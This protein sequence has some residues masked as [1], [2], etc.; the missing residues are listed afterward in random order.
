MNLKKLIILIIIFLSLSLFVLLSIVINNAQQLK[1]TRD[2]LTNTQHLLTK[3]KQ[4]LKTA[5]EKNWMNTNEIVSRQIVSDFFQTY[6]NYD[7]ATYIS[8]YK[9]MKI[10]AEP[11]VINMLKGAGDNFATPSIK[12]QTKTNSINFYRQ[13]ENSNNISGLCLVT[14]TSTVKDKQNAPINYL[15]SVVVNVK[16]NKISSVKLLGNIDMFTQE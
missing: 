4:R 9:K 15:Y 7:N 6:F 3:Q 10:Y 1:Q 16:T 5:E 13:L 11:N 2:N 14:I 12:V 8:R